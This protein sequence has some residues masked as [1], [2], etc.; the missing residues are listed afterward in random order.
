MYRALAILTTRTWDPLTDML[1]FTP[2]TSP[3]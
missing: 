2:M 1:L 3:G